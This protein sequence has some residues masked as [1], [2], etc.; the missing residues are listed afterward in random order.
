MER[1]GA[2][3]CLLHPIPHRE[4]VFLRLNYGNWHVWFVIEDR[5]GSLAF[6]VSNQF[7]P[8]DDP[9]FCEADLLAKCSL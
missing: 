9:A 1:L 6:A 7:T 2:I 4:R 5:V 3:E 8:N